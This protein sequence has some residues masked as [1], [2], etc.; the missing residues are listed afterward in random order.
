MSGIYRFLTVYMQAI[1]LEPELSRRQTEA[2][3]KCGRR[4]AQLSEPLGT[5]EPGRSQPEDKSADTCN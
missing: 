1:S 5:E 4:H 3:A 2:L